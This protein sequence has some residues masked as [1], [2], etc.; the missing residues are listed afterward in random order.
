MKEFYKDI[1]HWVDYDYVV[2][3]DNLDICYNEVIEVIEN[4]I[5]SKKKISFDKQRI[6]FNI[7]VQINGKKRTLI[8]TK[9]EM[10]EKDL[11]NQ[12]KNTQQI[13]KFIEGR[14]II[15]HIYI[16]NKLINLIVS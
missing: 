3:N 14:K 5:S 10:D 12:I 4:I 1:K 16:K 8:K 9:S 13:Q 11:L 2:I 7:V 6:E 15:K